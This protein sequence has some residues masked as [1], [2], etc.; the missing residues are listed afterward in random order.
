MYIKHPAG[1]DIQR[2]NDLK[3][4]G[5]VQ[6]AIMYADYRLQMYKYHHTGCPIKHFVQIQ[7]I[8]VLFKYLKI[9]IS[10]KVKSTEL[11]T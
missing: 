11:A 5:C 6:P 7:T 8:L 9:E 10:G 2:E 1:F 4:I 3:I